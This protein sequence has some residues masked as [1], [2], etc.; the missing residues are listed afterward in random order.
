MNVKPSSKNLKLKR[1]PSRTFGQWKDECQIEETP[2]DIR[3]EHEHVKSLGG[4]GSRRRE[5]EGAERFCNYSTKWRVQTPTPSGQNWIRR[6]TK[7]KSPLVFFRSQ[8]FVTIKVLF[9]TA[10]IFSN[11][12]QFQLIFSGKLPP[13]CAK[14][15]SQNPIRQTAKVRILNKTNVNTKNGKIKFWILFLED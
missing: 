2:A 10:L 7:D 12:S 9:P 5:D 1:Q 15:I 8:Y 6:E 13:S 4:G 14:S 11:P 3:E